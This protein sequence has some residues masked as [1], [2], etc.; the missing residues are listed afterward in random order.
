MII[1]KE[2]MDMPPKAKFTKEE[3]IAVAV[4]I[5]RDSGVEAITAKEIGKRMGTSTRPMFTWFKTVEELRMAATEEAR[6]IYNQYAERGLAMTPP[7][8]GLGMQCIRFATE[9]PNLF[10]LL[11][12]QKTE[13]NSAIDF[14]MHEEHMVQIRSAIMDTFHIDAAEA[15]WLYENLWIFNHGL[16]TLCA[17]ETLHFAQEDIA[18][19]LGNLCRGLLMVLKAPKDKRTDIVPEVGAAIPGGSMDYTKAPEEETN[20]ESGLAT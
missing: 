16:C 12:M 5:I 8:K 7:F 11:F 3:I 10:R 19:K 15:D 13:Q 6:K 1:A 2:G 4:D 9:E 20:G 18:Q 17:T 14:L